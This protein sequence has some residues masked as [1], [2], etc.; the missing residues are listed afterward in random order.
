[1][2]RAKRGNGVGPIC[3]VVTWCAGLTEDSHGFWRPTDN[4]FA[5][6]VIR[7]HP[8]PWEFF[9]PSDYR[10]L[11]VDGTIRRRDFPA[12]RQISFVPAAK[13]ITAR[14]TGPNAGFACNPSV[15]N[16]LARQMGLP[17]LETPDDSL[18]EQ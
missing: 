5:A 6:G 9:R 10:K 2:H 14:Q 12:T 8:Y 13:R 18:A 16:D 7:G 3:R 15:F 4:D 1:V 17:C 11:S